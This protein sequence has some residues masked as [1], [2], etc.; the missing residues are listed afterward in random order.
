ML[1]GQLVG[2]AIKDFNELFAA[3]SASLTEMLQQVQGQ[4]NVSDAN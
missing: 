1:K 2:H 3:R 4:P